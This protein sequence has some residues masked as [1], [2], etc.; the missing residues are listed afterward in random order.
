MVTV[1]A[2]EAK[3]RLPEL[4]RMVEAGERVTIT[5]HG[6]P[7]A[8]LTAPTGLPETTA[9]EAVEALAEFGKGRRLGATL[10]V[11]D[12]IEEGRR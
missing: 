10:S 1:G 6:R 2:Y 7:V 12:L 11:L 3:T 5:R 8:L 9:A 4:L